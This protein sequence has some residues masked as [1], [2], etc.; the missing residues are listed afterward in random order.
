MAKGN[1]DCIKYI[2]PSQFIPLLTY[3]S[4]LTW[5]FWFNKGELLQW[6]TSKLIRRNDVWSKRSKNTQSQMSKMNKFPGFVPFVIQL[7]K[8]GYNHE[9]FGTKRKTDWIS[10]QKTDVN[11]KTS[12]FYLI[13][14]RKLQHFPHFSL[15]NSLKF[16]LIL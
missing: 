11:N 10:W 5:W 16:C 3:S 2:Q 13:L 12:R 14:Q 15:L 4:Y 9:I 8:I 6:V 1:Y 7:S